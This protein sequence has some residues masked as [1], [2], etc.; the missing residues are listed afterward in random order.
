[1][2]VLLVT[3]YFPP[4]Y[5]GGAEV[6]LYNESHGL[7]E[8]GVDASV[9][10]INARMKERRDRRLEHEGL[11]L[12]EI[13]YRPCGLKS[14]AL[15][16]F[17]P[18]IYRD[19][20][21]ELHRLRPDLVHVHNVSGTTLAPF[22]ACRRLGLPVVLTLHDHWLLCPN[23]M[24]YRRDG[25]LCNA[26]ASSRTCNQCFQR[27][28]FWANV[29]GRRQLFARLVANVRLFI[30]PSQKLVDLHVAA[31]Y[32]RSRFCVVPNGIKPTLFEPPEDAAV[33][34][35]A[36]Q[37][38][39]RRTM[40][41]AGAIA[42]NKGIMTLVEAVPLLARYVPGFRLVVA[43]TGDQRLIEA[44]Q[45]LD[46]T[47]VQLLGQVPFRQMRA[48]YATAD[49]TVVPSLWYENSPMSIYES[50]LAGT[51]VLGSEVGGIPELIEP[52]RTG[53]TFRRGDPVSLTEKVIQHFSRSARERRS[54][55]R[56]CVERSHSY[57][58]LDRHLDRLQQVY[59]EVL[60][61]NRDRSKGR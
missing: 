42:E 59:G 30:S 43:G 9:L 57:M 7:R 15:Q 29:P 10:A 31:G 51:P 36:R 53:Y 50:L 24:L 12:H 35:I 32:R 38:G 61:D 34:A 26:S 4:H 8:R 45:R 52:G 3:N 47:A 58:T 13:T 28:D 25:S 18:R 1:V 6:V 56:Q 2:R 20:L 54:M 60:S 55:R 11:P 21:V 14:G 39:L 16:A 23:N 40:L 48:L 19:L 37:A 49:L 41:F 33:R 5:T 22:V 27:Y 44:L 17:D 46:Q